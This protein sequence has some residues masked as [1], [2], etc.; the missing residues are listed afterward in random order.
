MKFNIQAGC[1]KMDL[2]GLEPETSRTTD[3]SGA[4]LTKS[5]CVDCCPQLL[6]ICR[7]QLYAATR[8]QIAQPSGE[9]Y[10]DASY[11]YFA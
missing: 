1:N 3:E 2:S 6:I 4:A 5:R 11:G 8:T 10:I 9:L 7:P